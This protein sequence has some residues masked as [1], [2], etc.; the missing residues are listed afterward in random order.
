[1]LIGAGTASAAP[2]RERMAAMVEKCILFVVVGLENV[3]GGWRLYV[4]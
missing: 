2:E 3:F 4:D 1:M